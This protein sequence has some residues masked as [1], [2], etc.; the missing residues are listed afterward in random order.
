M[1]EDLYPSRKKDRPDRIRR[2]DP[3]V[4]ADSY[5]GGPIGPDLL[6]AYGAR[7]FMVLDDLFSPDEVEQMIDEVTRLREERAWLETDSVVSEPGDDTASAVRS[8]FRVHDQSEHFARLARDPRLLEIAEFILDDEVYIHQSR[9]NYKPAFKG[10]E[11]YWHSDF[12]TWH[13]EDG[14]PRMRALSMSVMLTDNHPQAGPVMFIPG[15]HKTFVS[16]VGETPEENYR[17]SLVR[18]SVGVPDKDSLAILAHERGI[19]GPAPAAGS[20]VVFD[21]N[22]LHGSGGNI[23]PFPRSN[24]FFVYNAWSNRLQAPFSAPSPRPPFV[25]ERS[26]GRPL[27]YERREKRA[28]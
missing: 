21:C 26:P 20:V 22:T 25:A 15:S 3:V 9:V 8:V 12:E 13:T 27:S 2:L 28:A 19:A 4:Y 10:K 5:K 17:N 23:T 16:C 6:R 24:A 11:F 14:M 18:Q 1:T 7:G